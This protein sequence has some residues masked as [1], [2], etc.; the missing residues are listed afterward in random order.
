MQGKF[1]ILQKIEKIKM[2]IKLKQELKDALMQITIKYV[3]DD[4]KSVM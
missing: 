3:G 2:D 4:E 1:E